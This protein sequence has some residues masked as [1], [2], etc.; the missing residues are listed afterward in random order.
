MRTQ[1]DL[2]INLAWREGLPY[3][4]AI[5]RVGEEER[6]DPVMTEVRTRYYL[7][8]AC[9]LTVMR[10]SPFL[11][12]CVVLFMT[13]NANIKHQMNPDFTQLRLAGYISGASSKTYYCR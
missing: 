8:G 10:F 4:E 7:P 13:P 12:S 3:E 9:K 6:G 2:R 5:D 1:N 11:A